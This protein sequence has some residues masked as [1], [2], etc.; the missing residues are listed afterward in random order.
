MQNMP[1]PVLPSVIVRLCLSGV[2]IP[3]KGAP[4]VN[5]PLPI[6]PAAGIKISGTPALSNYEAQIIRHELDQPNVRQNVPDISDI[7]QISKCFAKLS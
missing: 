2:K 7:R 4:L 1:L 6:Q 3:K 5:I